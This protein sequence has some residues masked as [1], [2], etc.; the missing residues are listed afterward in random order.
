[1]AAELPKSAKHGTKAAVEAEIVKK[2]VEEDSDGQLIANSTIE[3]WISKVE[4]VSVEVYQASKDRPI[5]FMEAVA[6]LGVKNALSSTPDEQH[7]LMLSLRSIGKVISDY[8]LAKKAKVESTRQA[9]I[10]KAARKRNLENLSQKAGKKE[11]KTK[12]KTTDDDADEE[13]EIALIAEGEEGDESADEISKKKKRR[14][15]GV[16]KSLLLKVKVMKNLTKKKAIVFLKDCQRLSPRQRLKL[17]LV[18]NWQLK[19]LKLRKKL[20]RPNS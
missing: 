15:R 14:H 6:K 9:S 19:M 18:Y 17:I 2:I 3:S 4:D 20:R 11:A 1:L 5:G 8:F 16:H 10:Q 13:K 7:R 12:K